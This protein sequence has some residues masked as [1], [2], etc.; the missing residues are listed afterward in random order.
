M[1]TVKK[2]VERF[3]KSSGSKNRLYASINHEDE[4]V[5]IKADEENESF[6]G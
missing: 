1:F 5:P 4:I 6:E 2:A 3:L